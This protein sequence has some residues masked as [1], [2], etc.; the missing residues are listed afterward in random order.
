MI[1]DVDECSPASDCMHQCENTAGGYNCK[2]DANFKVDP[3]DSKKCIREYT[4]SR[5]FI[6]CL[7]HSCKKTYF[8]KITFTLIV[9]NVIFIIIIL[10]QLKMY[11]QVNMAA[12]K[13]VIKQMDRTSVRVFRDMN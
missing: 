5:A 12:N 1:S 10:H 7:C 3:T 13:F 9:P 4:Y 8:L 2:C 6:A 11:V